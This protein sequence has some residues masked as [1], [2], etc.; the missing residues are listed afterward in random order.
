MINF[1]KIGDRN[2]GLQSN[3]GAG[4]GKV[5]GLIQSRRLSTLLHIINLYSDF[6][7]KLRDKQISLYTKPGVYT[8]S[9][10]LGPAFIGEE[11]KLTP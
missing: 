6:V 8:I 11:F 3:G 1:T 9:S 7:K 2:F 10:T 5:G 4:Q